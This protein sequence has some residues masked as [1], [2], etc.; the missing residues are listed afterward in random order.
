MSQNSMENIKM[1]TFKQKINLAVLVV[2]LVAFACF[3]AMAGVQFLPGSGK[4]G[5]VRASRGN[6]CMGYNLTTP[7]CAG[8]ACKVGWNC[9]SCTNAKGT[10]YKC[11]PLACDTVNGYVAGR[12]S[13]APC[14][15]Y[16]YKGFAGN[17]ICGKCNI[18]NGCLETSGEN[19][20]PFQYVIGV[21]INRDKIN[22]EK[23]TGY[24]LNN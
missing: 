14:Q 19:T 17:Q 4:N 13:C 8:K 16:E 15:Q 12:S 9:Q 11:V 3:E 18:I 7:K 5:N 6:P 24:R 22:N 21:T 20:Q 2:V 1:K 23:K 10:Y